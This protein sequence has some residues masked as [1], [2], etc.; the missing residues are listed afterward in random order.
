[1]A[2]PIDMF[3]VY[4]WKFWTHKAPWCC[5]KWWGYIEN[6]RS[7]FFQQFL[8]HLQTLLLLFFLSCGT[9]GWWKCY[10]NLQYG[11]MKFPE[12]KSERPQTIHMYRVLSFLICFVKSAFWSIIS[13]DWFRIMI[14]TDC[15]CIMAT[16]RI[17]KSVIL[18]LIYCCI[19]DVN[20][21][22]NR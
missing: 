11:V 22:R 9:T 16:Y 7:L 10:L 17:Y 1:M 3:D 12:S 6:I 4:V 15:Y 13:T 8:L 19:I 2:I 20:V 21:H 18:F 5:N 14:H